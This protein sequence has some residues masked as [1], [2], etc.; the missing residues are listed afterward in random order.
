[1]LFPA[2]AKLA[3]P[4]TTPI[5][6]VSVQ[7]EEILRYS[8][9]LILPEIGTLGQEAITKARVLVVGAGGGLGSAA[10]LYLAA[11][12]VGTLVAA[13][14]DVVELSNLQRQ[15]IHDTQALGL[16]KVDSLAKTLLRLNPHVEVQGRH[17]RADE[18]SALSLA[19]NA[20][21]VLDCTDCFSSRYAVN[22]A[23]LFLGVPLVS[24]ACV[25]FSGQISVFD[26]RNPASPCYECL[27]PDKGE[28]GDGACQ[29]QG[30]F[31]PL[32]GILGA[33]QAAEALKIITGAG[34]PLL[35]R[36]LFFDAL[37]METKTVRL[38]RDPLCPAC[39]G[40][41]QRKKL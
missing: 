27:Y 18:S 9:H 17:V 12:G 14:G 28:G 19:E 37:K 1:M 29:S 22:R 4:A 7:D 8:R 41:G 11:S 13:D 25:R 2:S 38:V 23:C 31:A 24:A 39:A 30:V 5:G 3:S 26:F 34:E 35:G 20:S 40:N 33:M 36:V 21:V 16:A 32:P 10:C 6:C 15:V